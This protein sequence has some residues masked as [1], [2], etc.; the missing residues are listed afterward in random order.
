MIGDERTIRGLSIKTHIGP[1]E[2]AFL[3]AMADKYK[4]EQTEVVRF[5]IRVMLDAK[6][7][8]RGVPCPHRWISDIIQDDMTP[9]LEQAGL[10]EGYEQG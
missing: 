4:C 10:L 5:C 7:G 3:K 1:E 8:K 6:R 9:E 2:A